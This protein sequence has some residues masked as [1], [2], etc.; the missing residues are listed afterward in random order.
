[1]NFFLDRN[2]PEALARMFAHYD[3]EHT[4]LWHDDRFKAT[5][6]DSE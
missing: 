5:A 2:I 6:P 4:I 1:M 3:R